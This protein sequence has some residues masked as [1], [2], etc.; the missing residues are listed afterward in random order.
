MRFQALMILSAYWLVFF[1][2]LTPTLAG[3][4]FT[5]YTTS[6][7]FTDA[8]GFDPNTEVSSGGFFSGVIGVFTAAARIFLLATLGI[9]LS[10][11]T[12]TWFQICF[13]SWQLFISIATILCIISLF[14]DK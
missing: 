9:G 5:G 8:S 10:I 2:I 1:L 13:S 3:N 4:P 7:N 12:P 6:G 14:W 11:D